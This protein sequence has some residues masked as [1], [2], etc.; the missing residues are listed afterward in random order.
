MHPAAEPFKEGLLEDGI[1]A[2]TYGVWDVHA[3]YEHL[4]GWR[5]RF[6]QPPVFMEPVTTT[7]LDDT[8]GSLIQIAQKHER[9]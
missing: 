6:T 7:V 9:S 1:P 5:G 8:C 4:C 3:K 2:T